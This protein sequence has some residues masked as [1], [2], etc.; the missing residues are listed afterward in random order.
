[1]ITKR[2][3]KR[4]VST[5]FRI[6]LFIFKKFFKFIGIEYNLYSLVYNVLSIER[7]SLSWTLRAHERAS[8][9]IN[10]LLTLPESYKNHL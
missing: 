4:N 2:I 9:S 6:F 5:R 1:M 8:L 10:F 7:I 3:T